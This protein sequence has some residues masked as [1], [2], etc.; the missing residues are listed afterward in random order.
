MAHVKKFFVSNRLPFS[1]DVKTGGVNRSTGGL[2][3]ALLGAKLQDNFSWFG[4]VSDSREAELLRAPEV[5]HKSG[6]V[7]EPVY[8]DKK[9]YDG[10]YN[11][12]CNDVLWPLFHYENQYVQ[13][14]RK[15]WNQYIEANRIMADAIIRAA[16][17]NSSVWIH[18]FH[19]FLLPEMI[20][21]ARPDIEIGFFLHIPFPSS[22]IYRQLPVR[23]EILKSLTYCNLLGFHDYSYLRH[24]LVSLKFILGLDST[25]FKVDMDHN[26]LNLGIYPI[27]IESEE[28]DKRSSSENVKA[29]V[30]QYQKDIPVEFL[31]LG[32]DRLDY[33]KGLELKLKGFRRLLQ[34]YPDVRGKVS[35]LQVAVPT[36]INVPGYVRLKREIDQLVGMINGEFGN[37]SYVPVNYIYNTIEIDV[38]LALYRRA[39]CALVTSKRDGM[40]LVCMEYVVAQGEG[41]DGVLVLSEFT[42]AASL[43]GDALLVNPWDE[44]SI[45]DAVYQGFKMPSSVRT[46][47]L[48]GMQT[49]LSKY[50]STEWAKTFLKDLAKT[51]TTKKIIRAK[52]LRPYDD[53]AKPQI[54]DAIQSKREINLI[55]DYDGT[56]VS[57]K[58]TPRLA[59]LPDQERV[60]LQDLT[61][62]LNIFIVSGR[63]RD[64]LTSQ[65]GDL[66]VNL[67]AEHGAYVFERE[68]GWVSK[69]TSNIE[70]W[71]PEVLRVM[72]DYADRVP[73]S[74]VEQKMSSIVWHY[75]ESPKKFAEFQANKL[76]EELQVAFANQPVVVSAGASI[77]E[78]RATECNKGNF[79]KGLAESKGEQSLIICLGDDRTDEDM[80]RA[81]GPGGL[82]IK[83]GLG[84]TIANY[85]LADQTEVFKFL[86]N[87]LTLFKAN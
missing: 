83:V 1:Y 33:T 30:E 80:F 68:N 58:K 18:D 46:E 74:F 20:K 13:F 63:D 38:L 49:V 67:V 51:A 45:A 69:V 32:I 7:V 71:Y 84:D 60:L 56:L 47:R 41:G 9:V 73:M 23:K 17:P 29:I 14:R 6:F 62:F 86:N 31:I 75:R 64:F 24:F 2:V 43:L 70:V 42:G 28:I 22:E 19:F 25:F 5:A 78:A 85:Q 37:P 59:V 81:L 50:S 53:I 65:F 15:D 54:H 4:F 36:R 72:Q 79:V 35:L 27:S 66:N 3:S 34:K 8:I 61:K 16:E 44:D 40:N 82:T 77:I 21:T 57:H 52:K 12:F 55:L 39:Q 48:R 10:Y 26:V 11:R 87:L 76:D